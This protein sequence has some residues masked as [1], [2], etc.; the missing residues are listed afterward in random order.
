MITEEQLEAEIKATQAFI[1]YLHKEHAE[2][3]FP[4]LQGY[5]DALIFVWRGKLD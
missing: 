2:E 5:L 3:D 1:K 4:E